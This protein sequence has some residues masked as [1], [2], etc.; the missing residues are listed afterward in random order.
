[1]GLSVAVGLLLTAFFTSVALLLSSLTRRKSYAAAGV[2][3]ITFGLTI[4]TEILASPGAIGN[5][6]LLYLSPWQDFLAV[7]RAAFGASGSPIDWP[8]S[9][10][11]L[12]C[13]TVLAAL[14]TYVRMK[15]VEVVSG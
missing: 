12:L 4:P 2:F 15:A 7:A 3:A 1:M 8:W 13:A 10:A 11:I 6:S 14:V 5:P 9:L